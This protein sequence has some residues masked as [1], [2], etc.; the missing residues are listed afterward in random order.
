MKNTITYYVRTKGSVVAEK[1]EAVGSDHL[2]VME[3]MERRTHLSVRAWNELD[4]VSRTR[5][6]LLCKP[7]ANGGWDVQQKVTVSF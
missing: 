2:D 5:Q 6:G 7:G 3:D 1:H 4:P